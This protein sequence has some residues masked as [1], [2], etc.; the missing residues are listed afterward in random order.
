M[1][2]Q[3]N[4]KNEIILSILTFPHFQAQFFVTNQ[5]PYPREQR[6]DQRHKGHE[7]DDVSDYA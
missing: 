2:F 7:R 3:Q 1:T 6:V 5:W 4:R